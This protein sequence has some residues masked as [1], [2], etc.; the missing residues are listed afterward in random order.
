MSETDTVLISKHM[1][2]DSVY[3]SNSTSQTP[4]EAKNHNNRVEYGFV[5]ENCFVQLK[6]NEAA[7]SWKLLKGKME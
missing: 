1:T 3:A 2:E 7:R 5:I 4:S 6:D